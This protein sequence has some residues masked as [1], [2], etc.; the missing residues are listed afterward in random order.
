MKTI[1]F[2]L[3]LLLTFVSAVD[4]VDPA[5]TLSVKTT[6]NQQSSLEEFVKEESTPDTTVVLGANNNLE[7]EDLGVSHEV[8]STN[9]DSYDIE[10]HL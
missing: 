3:L 1:I 4:L 8:E 7:H 9:V 5:S 2:A 10:E 6:E